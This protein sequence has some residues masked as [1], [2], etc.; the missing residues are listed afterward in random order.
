[1]VAW[2]HSFELAGGM[3]AF[4]HSQLSGSGQHAELRLATRLV[5][6]APSLMALLQSVAG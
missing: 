2:T 4:G 1:M 6:A 3:L 5:N